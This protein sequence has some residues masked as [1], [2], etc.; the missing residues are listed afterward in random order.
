M[1]NG[2]GGRSGFTIVELLVV[3]AVIGILGS[4]I[5]AAVSQVQGKSRIAAT[6]QFL[7]AIDTSL[8]AYFADEQKYPPDE[9]VNWSSSPGADSAVFA[10][11][12]SFIYT[13][14]HGKSVYFN[15]EDEK[16]STTN[17]NDKAIY[18]KDVWGG[19]VLYI[20]APDKRN[21][22]GYFTFPGG[23]V[24]KYNLWSPGPDGNC[25]SCSAAAGYSGDHAD[26]LAAQ[27][28]A[29]QGHLGGDKADSKDDVQ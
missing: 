7:S 5:I 24:A 10:P 18:A 25:D 4:I 8:Q 17:R 3:V 11:P 21:N 6:K 20:V 23:A 27:P 15:A 26:G 19:P 13:L 1:R 28:T 2:A 14:M 9:I 16:L 22:P 29:S 12:Q